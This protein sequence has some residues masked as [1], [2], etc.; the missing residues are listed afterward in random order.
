VVELYTSEGCNSCPPADRWLSTLRGRPEVI[1][2][3]FH[4]D[5]WDYIG[6][7][8]RFASAAFSERQRSRARTAGASF[9]YTP[10]VIADDADFSA[11]RRGGALPRPHAA[12]AGVRVRLESA[13]PAA[14]G[15]EARLSASL[16]VGA[17]RQ[18]VAWIALLEDGLASEVKAGENRGE[19]LAHDAVVRRW[20]G[21]FA[22]D[23][24]GRL[25]VSRTVALGDVAAG[26]ASL[27]AI[28]EREPGGRMLQ[29]LRLPLCR[30]A[31][32][33]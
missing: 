12:E 1:S 29:A 22:F 30:P 28:V 5:Y 8:D 19:R 11:W 9:V 24:A 18:A 26:R 15:I 10:Q 7:K 17:A 23:A 14:A 25:E 4:V 2:L 33:T 20:L 6:W 31:S 32:A 13:P 16:D 27:V 21:P 3:A